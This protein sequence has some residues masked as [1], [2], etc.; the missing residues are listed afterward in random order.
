MS[1]I[2][3]GSQISAIQL[4]GQ[5]KSKTSIYK[6]RNDKTHIKLVHE[7]YGTCFQYN[8]KNLE[9]TI[10]LHFCSD[11]AMCCW[12]LWRADYIEDFK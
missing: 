6:Y 11:N 7:L 9:P 1:F 3:K 8:A 5:F 10:E 2:L 12:F 4:K